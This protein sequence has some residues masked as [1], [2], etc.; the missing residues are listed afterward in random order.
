[1]LA[2]PQI[3]VGLALAVLGRKLFWL[4]VAGV[5]FLAALAI[6]SRFLQG[7]PEWLVIGLG[8]LAALVGALLAVFVQKVAIAVAGFVG[9]GFL[10][11]G[12][13][14]LIGFDPGR[15]AWL[16]FLVGGILGAILLAVA[17]DWALIV[18]SSL[19]G[20]ALVTEAVAPGQMASVI[21]Y[22]GLL[23]LG[24]VVQ[25]ALLHRERRGVVES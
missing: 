16:A 4:F 11:V 17:F 24:I 18:L 20:A 1:M 6:A 7:S 12:I 25:G 9:G 13:L 10:L 2:I 8:I 14:N 3:L 21:L 19:A 15:L 5:G 22:L 23:V